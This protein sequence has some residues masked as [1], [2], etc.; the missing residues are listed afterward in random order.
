[1]LANFYNFFIL[2]RYVN[3]PTEMFFIWPNM[4]LCQYN[5][6]ITDLYFL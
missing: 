3:E 5:V 4:K 2:A 1:M 6:S